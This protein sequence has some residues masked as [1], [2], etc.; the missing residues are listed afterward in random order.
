MQ[1]NY[2]KSLISLVIIIILIIIGIV[3]YKPITNLFSGVLGSKD[4]YTNSTQRESGG[5]KSIF[6]GL[7][8][9]KKTTPVKQSPKVV[10]LTTTNLNDKDLN[11]L[12]MS[13]S[14]IK[15]AY[16]DG[17]IFLLEKHY[18]EKTRADFV[19]TG[20]GKTIRTVKNVTFSNI[21]KF[22]ATKVLVSMTYVEMS[23][24]SEKEEMI[25]IRE[26]NGW[27]MGISETK[28]YFGR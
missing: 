2:S 15:Q 16:V 20:G 5:I 25:F 12:D 3:A 13:F 27:K 4:K 22:S 7:F 19:A 21:R 14:N 26:T 11:G 10:K 9:D 6:A 23:G 1:N 28:T 17:N 18:S 24:F 8:G